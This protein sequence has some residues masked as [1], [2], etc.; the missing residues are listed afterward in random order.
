MEM[1]ITGPKIVMLIWL[2]AVATTVIP[3]SLDAA[4]DF[5][6]GQQCW[7]EGQYRD[8]Y[9]HLWRYRQTPYG[10]SAYVDYM[11][12]T[13]GC[14][15]DDL[16]K[17]GC[18]VLEWMLNR[19]AL[20]E[21][22][23]SAV[24]NELALCRSTSPP[25]AISPGVATMIA[26]IIGA[27]A[28]SSAK[29]YYWIGKDEQ[30]NS[31][32]A[33]RVREIS[34]Q[35]LETRLIPLE[36]RD[37]ALHETI[38]RAPGFEVVVYER[39]VLASRS[40]HSRETMNRMAKYLEQYLRFLERQYGVSLPK[41]FVTVYMV[42]T[43]DDLIK[44]AERLHGLRVSRVTFGY[45]FRD[46][47]S[48]IVAIPNEFLIGTIMHEFFHLAVRSNFGDIP[49]WLDEGMAGLYEVSKFQ[50]EEVLGIPNWRGKVLASLMH[51]RPTVK[52]LVVSDWFAFEQVELAK[53]LQNDQY[54]DSP[55]A[56]QMAAM[57]ATARYFTFYL[58]EKGKLKSVFQ[59]LQKL[60]PGSGSEKPAQESIKIIE[61][62]L[63]KKI[64]LVDVEFQEWFRRVEKI[65]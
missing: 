56:E 64:D 18:D 22:G 1:K 39:F 43:S 48:V 63:G 60:T 58:Q 7:N 62:C 26:S 50:G 41:T 37:R 3:L 65:Q 8:A 11:L 38:Q 12:G 2:A 24:R 4:D 17:W 15:L 10:R 54:N 5:A 25:G 55:P 46:D 40:G 51:R 20:S 27:S 32:P 30:F 28:R 31:Y 34:K 36:A 21:Q 44:H 52:Q 29:S 53:Q 16:R 42:P 59:D 6:V 13:S 9:T 19:Y 33:Y 23:R 45:S 35:E 61:D 47:M 57:L 49:Q 14:R